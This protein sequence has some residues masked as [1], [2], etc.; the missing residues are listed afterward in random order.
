MYRIGLNFLSRRRSS[1]RKKRSF[2]RECN[3]ELKI[4]RFNVI[5]L[6]GAIYGEIYLK[7]L[8]QGKRRGYSDFRDFLTDI[9][10]RGLIRAKSGD[11][12]DMERRI[13]KRIIQTRDDSR[14]RTRIVKVDLNAIDVH[15]INRICRSHPEIDFYDCISYLLVIGWSHINGGVD[16][17]RDEGYEKIFC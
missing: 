16:F 12:G 8:S 15:L 2:I 14:R 3:P 9:A 13:M 6:P 10:I 5:R 1:L 7:Y 4:R 17:K 11:D